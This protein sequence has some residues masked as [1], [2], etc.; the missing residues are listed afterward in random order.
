[1]KCCSFAFNF[2][3]S[4][5]SCAKSNS[6]AVQ[7]LA[8]CF[9]YISHILGYL[10][11]NNTNRCLFSVNKNSCLSASA[12]AGVVGGVVSLFS[13]TFRSFSTC[14]CCFLLSSGWTN[15]DSDENVDIWKA[16]KFF[17][18]KDKK[19]RF[20]LEKKAITIYFLSSIFFFAVQFDSE[21][22]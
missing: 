17:M 3:Q 6:S 5:K 2:C 19:K 14:F 10:I 22:E 1:M 13:G 15:V 11:G 7:K 16:K 4:L 18:L 20:V 12:A 9:L 8:S 21:K